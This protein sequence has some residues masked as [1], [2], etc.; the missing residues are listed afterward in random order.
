[1][2][3]NTSVSLGEDYE[4]FIGEDVANDQHQNA[5]DMIRAGL[6]LPEEE[7]HRHTLLSNAIQKGL[8]SGIA[9]D[10]DPAQHLATLKS[11][12]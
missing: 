11:K 10:F 2:G 8:G 4:A 5:S 7:D 3:K 6:C 1:M 12:R 9:H